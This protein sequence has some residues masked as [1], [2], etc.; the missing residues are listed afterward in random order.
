MSQ[1]GMQFVG[2]DWS[3]AGPAAAQRT[4]IWTAVVRDGVLCELSSGRTRLEAT[5]HLIA[6]AEGAPRTVA[7]L[8]FAFSL[9]RWWTKEQGHASAPE[10]W[11]WA[12]E[13][14]AA[15]PDGWLTQLP[16]PFWGTNFRLRPTDAFDAVSAEF[17]RTELESKAPGA[18]PMSTFR[19]FGPGT[20]G[21]QSLRG[22][23]CLLALRD[24]GF[25]IWPFDPAGD[26]LVVEVFPRLL[27]RRLSHGMEKLSGDALR[28]A[29]IDAAPAG[30][31]GDGDA[32][33]D[34]LR[35][36]Q[37]AF[38]AAVSAWALWFG[39]E[40]LK[41]VVAE[42]PDETDRLEGRIW[43][44][45][46]GGPP[47]LTAPGEDRRARVASRAPVQRARRRTRSEGAV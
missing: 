34:L 24:A 28:A 35:A 10:V 19:L 30:F 42:E 41:A 1:D 33:A 14:M 3:G 23:P 45:P 4:A 9:P 11:A 21:A 40:G 25:S 47:P 29:F 17:R 16:V 43:S 13:R 38:D 27:V 12:A 6:L 46:A 7:G 36:N 44:L 32:K 8:D 39:R 37:D 5:E 31:A 15:D 20:V 2:V 26:Q 18:A 22:H